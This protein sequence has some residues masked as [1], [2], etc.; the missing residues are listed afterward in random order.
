M[1][2]ATIDPRPN[3]KI[4][5]AAAIH[6]EITPDLQKTKPRYYLILLHQSRSSFTS[7]H[8]SSNSGLFYVGNHHM[9]TQY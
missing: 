4:M 9:P 3:G 5:P 2:Q 8:N 6:S 1:R 7:H